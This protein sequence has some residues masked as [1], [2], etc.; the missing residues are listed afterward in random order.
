MI[1][2]RIN[3][4]GVSKL[5]TLTPEEETSFTESIENLKK[6]KLEQIIKERDAACIADVTYNNHQWQA[7]EKSQALLSQAILM[8]QAGVYVPSVWRTSNNVD[9]SVSLTDLIAIAGTIALQ[10]QTAY[11]TSWARKAN[12]EN[13]TTIL[14]IENV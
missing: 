12:L 7:D 9:V 4:Q 5:I 11:V 6:K 10:V 8:A 3:K 1:I 2:Q 14:D 13:A